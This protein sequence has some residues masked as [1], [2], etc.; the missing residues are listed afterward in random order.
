MSYQDEDLLGDGGN[1]GL[2][3]DPSGGNWF[4][5]YFPVALRLAHAVDVYQALA[6]AADGPEPSVAPRGQ[7]LSVQ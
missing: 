4:R 3:G 2:S 1:G 5:G 7:R 6:A